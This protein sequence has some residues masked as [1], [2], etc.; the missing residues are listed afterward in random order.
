MT[1]TVRAALIASF[2]ALGGTAASAQDSA[3]AAQCVAIGAVSGF[4]VIDDR[5]IVLN[6]GVD[7]FVLV[8]LDRRC[9]GLRSTT[10]I[11][12]S[13]ADNSNMCPPFAGFITPDD[14]WRCAVGRLDAVDS[15]EAAFALISERSVARPPAGQNDPRP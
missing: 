12:R 2:V 1:V 15:L 9:S 3:G 10:E 4:Q 8:T 14:G 11:R 6:S 5:H 13:F 7:D